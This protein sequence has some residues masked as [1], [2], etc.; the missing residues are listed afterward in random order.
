LAKKP[1]AIVIPI[2]KQHLLPFEDISLKQCLKVLGN[3]PV[4]LA[5]PE[6]LNVSAYRKYSSRLEVTAFNDDYFKGIEGYNHLMLSREFYRRFKS[7]KFILI[8]QLDSFVF[9]DELIHWCSQNYDYI[10]A[11]FVD[12]TW[13]VS[14]ATNMSKTRIRKYARFLFGQ[15]NL[16]IGNGGFSLRK[17]SKL[18][19]M[20]WL[21][22]KVTE[23][24]DYNEDLFWSFYIPGRMPFYKIPALEASLKFAFETNPKK[25][26]ELNNKQLPFGCHGW[27]KNDLE[28]WAPVLKEYG[29]DIKKD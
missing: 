5:V 11:P 23:K 21:F 17:V 28:F 18:R 8:Y 24:I 16:T 9:K 22:R 1:V 19:A 7:Y 6:S 14:L 27:E 4:Y 13:N 12:S 3:Y 25:C 26:L 10:G 29:Y 2:Y 20:L 15:V